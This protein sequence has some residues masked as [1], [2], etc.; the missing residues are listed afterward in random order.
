MITPYLRDRL[1]LSS[2][3][4]KWQYNYCKI[5]S[6]THIYVSWKPKYWRNLLGCPYWSGVG[7]VR[8]NIN[9][10]LISYYRYIFERNMSLLTVVLFFIGSCKY[11][12]RVFF[13]PTRSLPCRC[14]AFTRMGAI[15]AISQIWS[16]TYSQLY[17]AVAIRS[18]DSMACL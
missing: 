14:N 8:L 16:Y 4:L 10:G 15:Q 9:L 2:I 1:R 18:C 3:L 17:F 5:T 11:Y 12:F 13:F 7:S 6:Q